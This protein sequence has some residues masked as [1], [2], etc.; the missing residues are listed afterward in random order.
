[1]LS[2]IPLGLLL[3]G[4]SPIDLDGSFFVQMGVF[5]IAFLILRGLVFQPVMGLFDAREAAMGGSRDQADQMERDADEKRAH[6]EG[7]LRKVSEQAG[8]ERDRLRTDAQKLA[9]ELTEKARRENAATL[10]SAKA[11]LDLEAKEARDKA[12]EQVPG[13]AREIAEKLLHRSMS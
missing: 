6:F 2:S 3:S 1:M 7:E 8:K 10:S 4:G 11:Q 9:R 12:Q 13:L 5:F